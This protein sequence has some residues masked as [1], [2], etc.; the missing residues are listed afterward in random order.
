MPWEMPSASLDVVFT[1]NFFEHLPSKDRLSLAL[2]E[3]FRCLKAGGKLIA[4]GP[5]IKFLAGRYWDFFDH[6]IHL[7]DLSLAEAM[8]II[9]FR[10]VV[11]IPK[12]LPYTM[13]K[14]IQ[15]PLILVA[16]YVRFK[17]CWHLFGKQFLVVAVKP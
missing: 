8:E 9:G 2:G 1:S 11:Q 16:A 15:Y 10:T 17:I 5:N 6:H 4:M 12:F 7:T 14:S 3:A 13:E